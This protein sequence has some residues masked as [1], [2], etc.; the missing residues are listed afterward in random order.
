MIFGANFAAMASK[1]DD[2]IFEDDGYVAFH[3]S[4]DMEEASRRS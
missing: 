4:Y 2:V 3:S 1:R